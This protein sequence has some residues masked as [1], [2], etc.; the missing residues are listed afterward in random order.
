M[1]A[2]QAAMDIISELEYGGF[3]F[4]S[5]SLIPVEEWK[6]ISVYNQKGHF[7]D[8]SLYPEGQRIAI[9]DIQI[10]SK[11]AFDIFSEYYDLKYDNWEPVRTY[12]DQF[13]AE[14]TPANGAIF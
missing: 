14:N 4:F 12:L 11:Q 5:N 10:G 7:Y 6:A 1:E 2:Q 13:W 8:I 9:A 3:Y